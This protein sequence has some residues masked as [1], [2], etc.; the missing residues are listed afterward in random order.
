MKSPPQP[1]VALSRTSW[2]LLNLFRRRGSGR[3]GHHGA[4]QLY[5]VIKGDSAVSPDMALRLEK[6]IGGHGRCLAADAKRLS[7][8]PGSARA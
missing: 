1:G 3:I 4:Q 8:L 7:I 2:R 6:A 5:K